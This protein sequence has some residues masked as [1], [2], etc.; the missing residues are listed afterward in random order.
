[1]V[2]NTAS[3]MPY[4]LLETAEC[5]NLLGNRKQDIN[6]AAFDFETKISGEATF[7]KYVSL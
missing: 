6:V 5:L 1:M 4:V 2:F 7:H 3:V